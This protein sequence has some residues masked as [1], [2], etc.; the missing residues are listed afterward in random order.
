MPKITWDDGRAAEPDVR[1]F[2]PATQRNRAPILEVL[3][4]FLPPSG[5]VVEV[6]SGSGEHAVWF[7]QHLR[8]LIWQPSDPDPACRRSIAGHAAVAGCATLRRPLDLDVTAPVW[9]L[10]RAAAVVCIN[11]VHIAPWSAAEGLF[12]GAAR[13]LPPAGVLYLYGPCFQAGRGT[14]PSNLAF[15]RSLRARNA[16]WGLRDTGDLAALGAAHGLRLSETVA[17]PANN[18]SLIF[19]RG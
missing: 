9:P 8:P 16:A 11:L 3:A 19:Q 2:A 15:D 6:A 5:T 13:L 4:R 10:E 17:M 1:R 18:L 14:A 7:A 12:A